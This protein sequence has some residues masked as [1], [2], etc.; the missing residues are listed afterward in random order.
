MAGIYQTQRLNLEKI[1]LVNKIYAAAAAIDF[2]RKA[3]AIRGKAE[4]SRIAFEAG[5]SE[6]MTAFKEAQAT[7]DPETIILAEYTF[8]VQ[9]LQFCHENDTASRTSL[10][11]AIQFFDDAFTAI[12]IVEAK[13]QYQIAEKTY[14]QHKDYRFKGFPLDSFHVA[15]KSHKT[16]IQNILKSPGIDPIEKALL[17]QRYDNLIA[18]QTGYV[19]K[20]RKAL[21]GKSK[22]ST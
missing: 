21:I 20:Q 7:A 9:E 19:E 18:G 12:K 1:G 11:T 16:R 10:N 17:Q 6:A 15:C 2:G 4:E 22:T 8:L 3:Y 13:N 5:I 14:P